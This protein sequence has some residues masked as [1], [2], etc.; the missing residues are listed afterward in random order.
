MQQQSR[1]VLIQ[2]RLGLHARAAVK[3]VELAQSFDAILTIQNHEGKEATADSVMGLLML[4]SAQGEH[5][6]I[7]AEGSD[8]HPALEAVCHLI[9]DKFDE[10]E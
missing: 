7:S 10:D 1:T 8:A 2:N 5:V 6:T 4:E 3:L 9:E